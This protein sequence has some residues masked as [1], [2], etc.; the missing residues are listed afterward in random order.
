MSHQNVEI[1]RRASDARNRRD[2]DAALRDFHPEVEF[3]WS[4]SR[5]A[6]GGIVANVIRGRDQLRAWMLELLD[7]WEV[8]W[9]PEE[10]L[11][12]G[13]DQVLEVVSVR[14]QG[15]DGIEMGDR[16]AVLWTFDGDIAVR[17]KFFP[18]KERAFEALGL[19]EQDRA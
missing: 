9:Q 1:V 19:S 16:S 14:I 7:V 4:E 3:D 11:Q 12:V 5:S 2:V 18:S 13:P 17:L 10:I 15:H 6:A 8:T